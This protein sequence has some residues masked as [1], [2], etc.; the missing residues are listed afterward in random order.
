MAELSSEETV[1]LHDMCDV[2]KRSVGAV[3]EARLSGDIGADAAQ[4]VLAKADALV[5]K[6]L[7]EEE[8]ISALRADSD[9]QVL[10]VPALIVTGGLIYTGV[11]GGC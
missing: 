3:V 9:L 7:S 11:R 2:V 5:E 8:I 4:M 1:L 10:G 6:D